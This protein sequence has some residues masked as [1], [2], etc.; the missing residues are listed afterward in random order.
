RRKC[1]HLSLSRSWCR[2]F[3]RSACGPHCSR[4]SQSSCFLTA[5]SYVRSRKRQAPKLAPVRPVVD[6]PED[7]IHIL[8]VAVHVT[9]DLEDDD[10]FEDDVEEFEDGDLGDDDG[11]TH[12][13]GAGDK[14]D[15]KDRGTGHTTKEK[16]GKDAT[17]PVDKA[18]G[19]MPILK[20]VQRF[21]R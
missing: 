11:K 20:C 4:P 18:A 17:K 21:V 16:H 8:F 9:D 3:L 6:A 12:G 2:L 13:T 7:A 1:G 5:I 14:G 10:G 15:S 19:K